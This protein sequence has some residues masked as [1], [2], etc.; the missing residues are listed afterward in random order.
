MPAAPSTCGRVQHHRHQ[1]HG[2]RQHR[3]VRRRWQHQPRQRHLQLR[4]HHDGGGTDIDLTGDLLA[5]GDI[6]LTAG[7]DIDMKN[8]TGGFF[9]ADA[10]GG[11]FTADNITSDADIRIFADDDVTAGDLSAGLPVE[12][13][14]ALRIDTNGSVVVGNMVALGGIDVTADGSVTGL[15]VTTGD[16][17]ITEAN[18]AIT[19]GHISAGMVIRRTH[20]PGSVVLTQRFDHCRQRRAA[21]RSVRYQRPADGRQ[22]NDGRRPARPGSRNHR[23]WRYYRRRPRSACRFLNVHGRRRGYRQFWRRRGRHRIDLRGNSGCYQRLDHHRRRRSGSSWRR[24][25][26]L[27]TG[28]STPRKWYSSNRLHHAGNLFAATCAGNGVSITRAI[29]EDSVEMASTGGNNHRA[30][31]GGP[32]E[33]AHSATSHNDITPAP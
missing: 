16:V 22:C 13:S 11:T 7:G 12:S 27:T 24:R 26:W 10:L 2:G 5:D 15:N 30:H 1:H 28:K 4:R 20:E 33:L 6:L 25:D 14:K 21:G 32:V 29:D 3:A 23:H 31:G 18:G 8:A 19:Y 9:Q 17:L